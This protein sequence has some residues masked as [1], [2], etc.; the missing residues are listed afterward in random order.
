MRFDVTE[1]EANLIVQSLGKQPFE[2]VYQL[3]GKLQ[4]QAQ[5]ANKPK[6]QDEP[7]K[8]DGTAN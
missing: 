3:I 5:E 2:I 7:S 1:Q 4:V 6:E 8:S